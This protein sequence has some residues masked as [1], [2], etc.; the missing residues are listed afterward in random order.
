[1]KKILVIEDEQGVRESILDIL[2]SEDFYAISAENGR[3]GVQLAEEFEP[4]LIICD[5]MMPELDGYGVLKHL[6]QNSKTSTIPFVFLTAKA[7]RTDIRH[8]MSLGADDYLTKP[9][10]H[11][12]LL[13]AIATR[14]DKQAIYTQ[15]S[16]EKLDSLRQ[17]ISLALPHELNTALSVINGMASILMQEHKTIAPA[18]IY[19]L[20]QSIHEG[21]K[22]LNRLIQNFLLIARLEVM[23]SKPEQ[24]ETLRRGQIDETADVIAGAA[25]IKAQAYGREAD[26]TL[27]LADASAT[28]SEQH[29]RK[30]VEEL[31][32][33]A[34]K[35]SPKGSQIRLFSAAS[36]NWLT[37]D[38]IDYGHG[39]TAEQ[40]AQ[41]GAYMQF[42]RH[43]QEQ[44]GVGLGLTIAKRIT[45]LHGGTLTIES[46]P[47][48]QTIICVSL[49]R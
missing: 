33:N 5:V 10:T 3:E 46:I 45:E 43:I 8:G 31:I 49:P 42:E 38:V 36:D 37:L 48:K 23:A 1:M 27:E 19:E 32:D 29:L 14:L 28:I 13:Q 34:C 12:E 2:N 30:L 40:I 21:S 7:D 17:N 15:Q 47:G 26:L 18:E 22:R 24:L 16:E 35:F 6:Q 41:V 9:F 25:T 44:T 20:A 4:N 11:A 39:M